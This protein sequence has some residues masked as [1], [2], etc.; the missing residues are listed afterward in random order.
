MYFIAK[1]R[2]DLFVY[3][4]ECSNMLLSQNLENQLYSSKYRQLEVNNFIELHLPQGYCRTLIMN[5][6]ICKCTLSAKEYLA[7]PVTRESLG[8]NAKLIVGSNSK[9]RKSA[10]KSTKTSKKSSINAF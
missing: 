1:T 6:D 4:P 8:D 2:P 9:K 7:D 5:R 3:F 10:S